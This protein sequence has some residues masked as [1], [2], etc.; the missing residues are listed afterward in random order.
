MAHGGISSRSVAKARKPPVE[1]R[2]LERFLTVAEAYSLSRAALSLGLTQSGISRQI[3]SLESRLNV[4]LFERTGRGVVLTQA[5]EVESRLAER[6]RVT[7]IGRHRD[8]T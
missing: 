3:A 8:V 6:Q 1:L 5:R 4:R 2:E 7:R